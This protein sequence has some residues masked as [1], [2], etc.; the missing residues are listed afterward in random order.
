M[1][2]STDDHKEIE[3]NLIYKLDRENLVNTPSLPKIK[4]NLHK[5]LNSAHNRPKKVN[6]TSNLQR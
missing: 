1:R 4:L 2:Q 3:E 5:G 6:S